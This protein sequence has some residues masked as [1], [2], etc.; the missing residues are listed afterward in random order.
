MVGQRVVVRRL[1]RDETGPSGGPAMTDVLGV[2]ERWAD[3]EVLVRREDGTTVLIAT[4]DIVAGKPVPPRPSR[5]SRL[6]A[7]TVERR[8][9]GIFRP[10]ESERCGNWLFRFSG[11]DRSRPNSILALGEP[12]T[13]LARL[14]SEADRFYAAHGRRPMAQVVLNSS[15]ERVLLDVGWVDRDPDESDTDVLLAGVAALSRNLRGCAAPPSF[16]ARRADRISREWLVGNE[17]ALANY[18]TIEATLALDDATFVSV[19][20]GDRQVARGRINLVGDWALFGDLRV[21]QD[22][23][24]E[25]L[26]HLV[27]AEVSAWAGERGA[28]AMLLQVRADNEPAQRL[29]ASLGFERHHAYRYLV[30]PT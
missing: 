29:Y 9:A 11:G 8:A 16:E 6:S 10:L 14:L 20:D 2:C 15:A 18:D 19:E 24:R 4:R 7:E 17:H 1:L 23:Q 26:A 27:M 5:F 13:D 30:P 28:S 21:Q 3:G 22:R 12:G 25:G